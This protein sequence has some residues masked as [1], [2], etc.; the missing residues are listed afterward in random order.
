MLLTKEEP[1]AVERIA[2]GTGGA[3]GGVCVGLTDVRVLTDCMRVSSRI[4]VLSAWIGVG[5]GRT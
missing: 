1:R 2:P 3:G 5:G 4:G